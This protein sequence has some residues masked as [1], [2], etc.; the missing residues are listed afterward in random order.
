MATSIHIQQVRQV[1]ALN[2]FD[3]FAG[4]WL[5]CAPFIW[6]YSANGGSVATDIIVGFAVLVLASIQMLSGNNRASW[7][8]WI[9]AV[10][11]VWLFAAPFVL[12]Y[13]TGSAAL[14]NDIIL[15]IIIGISA[16]ISAL[17]VQPSDQI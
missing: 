11:G 14:W 17:T 13:P 9:N 3:M 2:E 6:N 12:S 8:S 15:G 16:L 5:I 4:L 10:L 7:P 1:R